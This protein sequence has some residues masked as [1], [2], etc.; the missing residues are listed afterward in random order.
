MSAQDNRDSIKNQ[1]TYI[2]RLQSTNPTASERESKPYGLSMKELEYKRTHRS[3]RNI[4]TEAL[5]QVATKMAPSLNNLSQPSGQISPLVI[6]PPNERESHVEAKESPR[7]SEGSHRQAMARG[8]RTKRYCRISQHRKLASRL[9]W[10]VLIAITIQTLAIFVF[11]YI[12]VNSA[13]RGGP[14][15]QDVDNESTKYAWDLDLALY[16]AVGATALLH[17]RASSSRSCFTTRIR[18]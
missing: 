4:K 8:S 12:G 13:R 10:V 11:A 1:S 5:A 18:T 7:G 2:L 6:T 9:G 17:Y 15:S 14:Y 3:V 16:V